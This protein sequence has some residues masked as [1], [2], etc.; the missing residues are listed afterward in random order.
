MSCSAVFPAQP[1]I[2][3]KEA[4]LSD[5]IRCM[6][7]TSV[8]QSR[9]SLVSIHCQQVCPVPPR[10]PRPPLSSDNGRY[11][12]NFTDRSLQSVVHLTIQTDTLSN[13]VIRYLRFCNDVSMALWNNLII[14]KVSRLD[15]VIV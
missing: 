14:V 15:T 1:F 8:I 9:L 3:C 13:A 4:P 2:S 11:L 6:I 7:D 12:P 5:V 10:L